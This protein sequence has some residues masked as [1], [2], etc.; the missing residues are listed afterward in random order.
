MLTNTGLYV[1]EPVLTDMI[2][3]GEFVHT[4]ELIQRLIN[5]GENVGVYPVSE[6]AWL[7]IGQPEGLK[8][9][10]TAWL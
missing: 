1:M 10:N 7:D 5:M 6:N 3:D 4:T 8:N 9:I 2:S